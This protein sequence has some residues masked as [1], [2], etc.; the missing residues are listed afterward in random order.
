MEE[1]RKLQHDLE[2]YRSLLPLTTDPQ[3]IAV[4]EE[5]IRETQNRLDQLDTGNGERS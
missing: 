1:R 4:L 3:A 5:L 2:R